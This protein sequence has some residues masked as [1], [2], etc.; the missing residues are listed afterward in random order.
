MIRNRWVLIFLGGW[1]WLG[2]AGSAPAGE[3][4]VLVL[5]CTDS[6]AAADL[7]GK[8]PAVYLGNG[9]FDASGF[10]ANGEI[11]QTDFK[12]LI[13]TKLQKPKGMVRLKITKG[14]EVDI[15]VVTSIRMDTSDQAV[16]LP[17]APLQWF[18]DP[19][20]FVSTPPT[21][22]SG[23]V[24]TVSQPLTLSILRTA[25]FLLKE[26]QRP[27][28]LESGGIAKAS[29]LF[30]VTFKVSA[31]VTAFYCIYP[32][33]Q[34]VYYYYRERYKLKFEN[35]VLTLSFEDQKANQLNVETL[36]T[37][38]SENW[39]LMAG[40][41]RPPTTWTLINLGTIPRAFTSGWIGPPTIFL[42]PV[43]AY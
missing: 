24:T 34:K 11:N 18:T 22:S 9:D 13:Q 6:T 36:M 37:G 29:S 41:P 30:G 20:S 16:A 23:P 40:G 14:D 28:A 42:T 31:P 10:T 5:D 32:A 38:K 33:P 26:Q 12:S 19:I 35:S 8:L 1:F 21:R 2:A 27:S 17:N 3:G 7:T 25:R 39:F 43:C 4:N 15:Y